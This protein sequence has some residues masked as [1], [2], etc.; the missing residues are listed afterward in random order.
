MMSFLLDTSPEQDFLLVWRPV[1]GQELEVGL[2]GYLF[3]VFQQRGSLCIVALDGFESH[4]AAAVR[5]FETVY[6]TS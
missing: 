3:L 4:L 1:I 6:S 2:V 5:K